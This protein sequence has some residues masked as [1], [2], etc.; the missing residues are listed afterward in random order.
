[1]ADV[2]KSESPAAE[3]SSEPS[4]AVQPSEPSE[5]SSATPDPS[6]PKAAL[7]ARMA[8]FV[9]LK[10]LAADARKANSH[11]VRD[12]E[13]KKKTSAEE[14]KKIH[15][16]R[17]AAEIKL[18][19]DSDPDFERKR[20]WDYTADEDAMWEKRQGKKARN[21]DNT[22]FTDFRAEANKTYKR[23]VK[24]IVKVDRE[25]YI[26]QKAEKLEKQVRMGLLELV[27]TEEGDVFTVRED[28][29]IDE[30]VE[31]HYNFDHR[32]SKEAVDRL[33]KDLDRAEES[34]KKKRG[35]KEET[36]DVTYINAKNRQFNEKL[37]RFYNRYTTSIRESFERGTAI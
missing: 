37:A 15:L 31:E 21:K 11:A 7:A 5:P 14:L 23:Q 18:L 20:A 28:G 10:T 34:R 35:E 25:E 13:R 36:G 29:R 26:K 12:E 2:K 4:T 1:M 9:A 8:R 16:R 33:V 6:D 24:N 22:A 19:K 3:A 27:E 32:P 17:D 30:P